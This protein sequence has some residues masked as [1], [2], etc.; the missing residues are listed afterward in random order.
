MDPAKTAC[1]TLLQAT[2][3]FA[4]QCLQRYGEFYPFGAVMTAA[5]E[6]VLVGGTA[7]SDMPLSADVIERL[8]DGFIQGATRGEYAATA[9]VYDSRLKLAPDASKSDAI[10]ICLDHCDDYS[11]VI[12][13]PYHLDN[14]QLTLDDCIQQHGAFAIFPSRPPVN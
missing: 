3:P 11:V 14:G 13:Y 7:D 6:V 10:T 5:G 9:L 8:R 4:H 12:Y 2:L 1:E